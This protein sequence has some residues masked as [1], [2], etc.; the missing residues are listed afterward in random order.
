MSGLTDG[1]FMPGRTGRVSNKYS[2]IGVYNRHTIVN[3]IVFSDEP[4]ESIQGNNSGQFIPQDDILQDDIPQDDI[5]NESGV[6][7]L[8]LDSK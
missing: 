3:A 5:S 8:E 7:P 6:F 1:F 4:F 2:K